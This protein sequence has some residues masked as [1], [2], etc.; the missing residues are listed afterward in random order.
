ML[1]PEKS[2]RNFFVQ[3]TPENASAAQWRDGLNFK[4]ILAK[5]RARRS[6]IWQW[7]VLSGILGLLGGVGYSLLRVPAFSAASD[8]LVS[9]TTLQLSGQDAVVTQIM[10]ETSLF[11]SQMELVRSN[12]VLGRVIEAFGV[13][14]LEAMLPKRRLSVSGLDMVTTGSKPVASRRSEFLLAALKENVSAKR[15]GA[16]QIMTIQA[17]AETAEQAADLTN[18]VATAFVKEQMEANSLVTTSAAFRERIKV[19]GPTVRIIGEAL[20]PENKDGPRAILVLA[21]AG[22][23]AGGLGLVVALAVVLLDRRIRTAEQLAAITPVECFG[24]LPKLSADR[25]MS[26][27]MP[28]LRRA[29]SAALERSSATPRVFGITSCHAGEGKSMLAFHL[30]RLVAADGRQVLLVDAAGDS[31]K[32]SRSIAPISVTGLHDALRDNALPPS[33]VMKEIAPR[34]DFLPCGNVEGDVDTKWPGFARLISAD[35]GPGYAWI[36]LDLPPLNPVADVRAAAQVMD[37]LLLVVEWGKTSESALVAALDALGP[38]RDRIFG[39]VINKT[40]SGAGAN[41]WQPARE[42]VAAWSSKVGK[43]TNGLLAKSIGNS[44]ATAGADRASRKES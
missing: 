14:P 28:V 32:L 23:A 31:P 12:R 17:R 36:I 15:L 8:L 11:Q 18:A 4:I 35:R 40:P 20:K 39:I 3:S 5:L 13:E 25:P 44:A 29:R 42:R 2:P 21:L 19:L 38:A 6:L 9:N 16:S 10:V 43:K 33:A 37:D 41:A 30:A 22:G 7:M 34:L 24:L 1:D 27:L 26:T